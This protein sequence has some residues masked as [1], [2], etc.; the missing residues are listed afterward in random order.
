MS[1]LFVD[2][3]FAR[4]WADL[5]RDVLMAGNRIKIVHTVSRHI[6]EMMEA[7]AKWVPIY[8]TGAIEPL[9][10]PGLRDGLFQRTMFIA[11]F[12]GAVIANSV[13]RDS[14]GMLNIY[15]EDQEAIRALT[16][17]YNR[18]LACCQQRDRKSVV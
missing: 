5:L 18:Y 17:E 14:S 11:P 2:P 1:W 3:A 10:Y 15:L 16:V 13:N 12:S 6:D 8:L 7:V 9:Y 4:Q